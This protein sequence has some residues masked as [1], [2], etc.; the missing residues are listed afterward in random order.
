ELK[1]LGVEAFRHLLGFSIYSFLEGVT[2]MKSLSPDNIR[3]LGIKMI[4]ALAIG[5]AVIGAI[6]LVFSLGSVAGGF[7]SKL[8]S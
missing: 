1:A 5:V 4:K 8:L 7:F 2:T 3:L 6:I